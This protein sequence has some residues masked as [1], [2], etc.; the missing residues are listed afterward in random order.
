MDKFIRVYDNV[1]DESL[2]KQLIVNS[3]EPTYKW[4]E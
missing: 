1:I 3:K 2:S 4:K